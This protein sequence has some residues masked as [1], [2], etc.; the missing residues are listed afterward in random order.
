MTTLADLRPISKTR[1]ESKICE[2]WLRRA[3]LAALDGKID[4]DQ[5]GG[6]AGRSSDHYITKLYNEILAASDK[7]YAAMITSYDYSKA[8]N[9]MARS[10]VL[11]ACSKMGVKK[12][13]IRLLASYLDGREFFVDWNGAYSDLQ[14]SKGGCGQGTLFSVLLFITSINRLIQQLKAKSKEIEPNYEFP[15]T[16]L[17]FM[18]DLLCVTYRKYAEFRRNEENNRVFEDTGKI[19]SFLDVITNF[20]NTS[21]LRLNES[22]TVACTI[23]HSRP[24]RL[25]E[26]GCLQFRSGKEIEIKKEFRLLGVQIQQDLKMDSYV[27]ARR[28]SASFALWHLRKLSA[29]GVKGDHLLQAFKSYVRS[30]LEYALMPTYPLLT[31]KQWNSLESI[32][33]RATRLILGIT[34]Q[35]GPSVPSYQDRLQQLGLE[36]IEMRT[37]ARWEKFAIENEFAPQYQQY[38]EV[39]RN[40]ANVRKPRDYVVPKARTTRYKNAPFCRMAA[41]FNALPSTRTNRF[42][43]QQLQRQQQQQRLQ[44]QQRRAAAAAAVRA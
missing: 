33:K 44:Q 39:C 34:V 25:Y 2:F 17:L 27:K 6:V 23:D 38:F 40:G 15:A 22:K 1:V 10:D 11:D 9:S 4:P 21:G 26:E 35:Y 28:K 30:K 13:L 31:R 5:Y 41:F 19:A 42:E 32:Q 7:N 29:A 8:F 18:D 43:Q 3:L 16:C 12:P 14:T 20:S 36:S 37:K 24:R